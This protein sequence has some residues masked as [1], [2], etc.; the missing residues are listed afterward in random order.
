MTAP[1]SRR[2][3]T[4]GSET[5][6]CPSPPPRFHISTG[7]T[8]T[9]TITSPV[10][11]KLA[12]AIVRDVCVAPLATPQYSNDDDY[13]A[14]VDAITGEVTLNATGTTVITATYSG[15]THY[16]LTT[17]SYTLTVIKAALDSF[18]FTKVP[19]VGPQPVDAG[20]RTL[21]GRLPYGDVPGD[22]EATPT[23]C[24]LCTEPAGQVTYSIADTTVATVDK[25]S[26]RVT[27]TKV[28]TTRFIASYSGDET[29]S[30]Q[31]IERPFIVT[32]RALT[33]RQ[34]AF[35]CAPL[36]FRGA[37]FG[38]R[39]GCPATY[40]AVADD[41]ANCAA[42]PSGYV[43]YRIVEADA[44][45]IGVTVLDDGS[46]D[47]G[48]GYSTYWSLGIVNGREAF[49][50]TATVEATMEADERYSAA[51]ATLSMSFAR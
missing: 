24:Q 34:F 19:E 6:S 9:V 49:L 46:V 25:W 27:V 26:G 20:S 7:P 38:A 37:D 11:T 13:V 5:R 50:K 42:A 39:R 29:Y 31:S 16:L 41:C 47:P 22:V 40:R 32:K 43:T 21:D 45:R 23:G 44:R 2:S 8:R 3:S 48:S 1:G 28:G 33:S 51:T 4:L 35:D 30:P 36:Y 12:T 18:V 10:E 14:S 17:A 15:D